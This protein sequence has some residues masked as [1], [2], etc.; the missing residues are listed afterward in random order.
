MDISFTGVDQVVSVRNVA[1]VTALNAMYQLR[2]KSYSFCHQLRFKKSEVK[3]QLEH[4]VRC[5]C[6]FNFPDMIMPFWV[7]PL[8]RWMFHHPSQF[9]IPM[10]VLL[11]D[12]G[13]MTMQYLGQGE[14][15]LLQTGS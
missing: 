15:H 4:L 1:L 14:I 9:F 10:R 13:M 3:R 11:G 5:D 6:F 7:S 2:R 8:K 12:F